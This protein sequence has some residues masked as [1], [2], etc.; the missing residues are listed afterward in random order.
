MRQSSHDGI[1]IINIKTSILYLWK[2]QQIRLH[3]Y[4]VTEYVSILNS[5]SAPCSVNG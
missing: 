2:H 3:E 5:P 1:E 4:L